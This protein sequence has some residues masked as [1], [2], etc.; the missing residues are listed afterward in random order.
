MEGATVIFCDQKKPK[1]ILIQK[2]LKKGKIFWYFSPKKRGICV[3]KILKKFFFNYFWMF[4]C[5]KSI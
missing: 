2:T 4:F 3:Q 1:E 5:Q